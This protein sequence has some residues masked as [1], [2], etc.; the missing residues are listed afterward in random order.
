MQGLELVH[1]NIYLS[2]E[3]QKH[4][5]GNPKLQDLHDTGPQEEES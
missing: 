2:Y 1:P 3:L 4:V 5:N